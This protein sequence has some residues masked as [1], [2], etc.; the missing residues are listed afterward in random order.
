MNFENY[1]ERSRGFV[2]LAQDL[3]MR[4]DHQQLKP[5]HLLKL[6]LEDKEGLAIGLIRDAGGDPT[7]AL[8]GAEAALAALPK[9]EGSGAGQVYPA[10]ELVRFFEQAEELAEHRELARAVVLRLDGPRRRGAAMLLRRRRA[11]GPRFDHHAPSCGDFYA[12]TERWRRQPL[13]HSA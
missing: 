11:D 6:L 2:Q 13:G 4:E 5:E 12:E 1:T 9:V 3:A 8:K 10:R 7:A